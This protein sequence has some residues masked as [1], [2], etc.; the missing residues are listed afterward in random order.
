MM[1][2]LY[3][4]SSASTRMQLGCTRFTALQ[5]DRGVWSAVASGNAARRSAKRP[6][7]KGSDRPTRFS[8][9][10]DCD[11]CMPSEVPSA[12]GVP[13]SARSMP[14]SYIPCPASCRLPKKADGKK[15]SSNRVVTRTSSIE[16]DVVKGCD[17]TSCRPRSKSYPICARTVSVS[18]LCASTGYGRK[19]TASSIGE[20]AVMAC[21]IGTSRV[22]RS[23]KTRRSSAVVMPFSY[24]ST[25][26]SYRCSGY[27]SASARS[28]QSATIVSRCGANLR[29]SL[30]SR[31]ACHASRA[32][33]VSRAKRATRS[34][35]TLRARSKSSRATRTRSASISLSGR[36]A[37]SR[38]P[39]SSF[40]N[41]S[42]ASSCRV[43]SWRARAAVP[44]VGMK[45]SWS[46]SSTAAAA[47]RSLMRARRVFRRSIDTGR[48]PG[49]FSAFLERGVSIAASCRPM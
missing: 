36:A 2:R 49:L 34:D 11:S 7:Q 13:S 24:S 4:T 32:S 25:S 38:L 46:Q 12:S 10:R 45:V 31:A 1:W 21:T 33:D 43:A 3:V 37:S 14:C 44:P 22:R 8:Q 20:A 19:S 47:C 30:P 6:S 23:P 15:R 5:N 28:T 16:K 29:K 26:A 48:L 35:G 27:P 42:C 9:S 18:R 17:D 39:V 40:V 41:S